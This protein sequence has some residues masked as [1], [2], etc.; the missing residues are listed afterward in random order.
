MRADRGAVL[1]E[2]LV[3]LTLVTVTGSALV[4]LLAGASQSQAFYAAREDEMGEASVVLQ[5]CSLMSREDLDQRLGRHATGKWL[6]HIERPEPSLYRVGI[7]L[8]AAPAHELLVTVLFR[9]TT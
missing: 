9:P 4:G 5:R 7:A 1:L 2:V 8:Q 3:A 6:V